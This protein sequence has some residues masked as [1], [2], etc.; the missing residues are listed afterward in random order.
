M[1][2]L[3][4]YLTQNSK[5]S[6]LKESL[7]NQIRKTC[8]DILQKL[9]PSK[10]EPGGIINR[11][12]KNRDSSNL[13]IAETCLRKH[14]KMMNQVLLHRLIF[15]ENEENSQ[16]AT[17]LTI[18]LYKQL[19]PDNDESYVYFREN[20][21]HDTKLM[22]NRVGDN[23]FFEV[24]PEKTDEEEK[25]I[26]S[27]SKSEKSEKSENSGKSDKNKSTKPKHTTKNASSSKTSKTD[28]TDNTSN[29]PFLTQKIALS[30]LP[31]TEVCLDMASFTPNLE[32]NSEITKLPLASQSI[33]TLREIPFLNLIVINIGSSGNETE[34]QKSRDSINLMLPYWIK[35]LTKEA[36]S[37]NSG[38]GLPEKAH[39]RFVNTGRFLWN[40][41][42]WAKNP[43]LN[44]KVIKMH[45]GIKT[46]NFRSFQVVLAVSRHFSKTTLYSNQDLK[47]LWFFVKK[48]SGTRIRC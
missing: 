35:A 11:Q 17:Q 45:C 28:K 8:I 13:T 34:R 39:N 16:L 12:D 10:S 22:F 32:K 20:L 5:P 24:E 2:Q 42:F 46:G 19:R 23:T 18:T 33:L 6:Q 37:F 44:F 27:D 43:L 7:K 14:C 15:E 21:I 36:S 25:N 47:H 30:D 1:P 9:I 26:A 40:V 3:I 31:T 4:F 38:K 48:H 29:L 41:G